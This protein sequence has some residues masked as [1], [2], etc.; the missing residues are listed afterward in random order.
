MKVLLFVVQVIAA[1]SFGIGAVKGFWLGHWG[2]ATLSTAGAFICGFGAFAC[3][4][5]MTGAQ[6]RLPRPRRSHNCPLC[7]S[8]P[9]KCRG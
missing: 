5:E 4:S 6:V 9:C 8:S 7:N 1:I 2:S 3:L